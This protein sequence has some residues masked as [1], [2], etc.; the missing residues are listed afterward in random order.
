[1]H[2][3]EVSKVQSVQDKGTA[4]VF[5]KTNVS[6]LSEELEHLIKYGIETRWKSL[7][8]EIKI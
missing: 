6:V 4:S 2:R 8:E 5:Q 7:S 1:M 3:R